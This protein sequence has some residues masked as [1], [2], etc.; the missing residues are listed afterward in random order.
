MGDT[1]VQRFCGRHRWRKG[2]V[3]YGP[4]DVRNLIGRHT[5]DVEI[6]DNLGRRV[7]EPRHEVAESDTAILPAAAVISAHLTGLDSRRTAVRL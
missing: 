2:D 4:R 1:T 5:P 6:P 7:Y 3:G